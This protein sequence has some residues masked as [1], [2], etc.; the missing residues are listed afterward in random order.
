MRSPSLSSMALLSADGSFVRGA[1]FPRRSSGDDAQRALAPLVLEVGC[2]N[3]H[4]L[5]EYA[6]R[7][8]E[9]DCIGIDLRES[10]LARACRK[11]ELRHIPNL[12][13]AR[14]DVFALLQGYFSGVSF[15]RI[16]VTF[17]DPWPKYRHREKRLNHAPHLAALL[18]SLEPGG[19]FIWICDYYPQIVDV[20][21]LMQPSVRQGAFINAFGA[22]GFGEGLEDCPRTLYEA[23]WRAMGRRIY[24][25]KFIRS[26]G[27][28][29]PGFLL[30]DSVPLQDAQDAL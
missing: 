11:A 23:R 15:T 29:E 9:C 28:G 26:G 19:E 5:A 12:R 20:L 7:F 8:P 22:D 10:R 18:A 14:G 24:Y 17:P 25:V 2:G 30:R 1:A 3:G 21:L 13:F 16:F 27:E 4:F 6:L